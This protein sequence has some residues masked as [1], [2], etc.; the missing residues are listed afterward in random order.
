MTLSYGIAIARVWQE[1]ETV[2]ERYLRGDY[3]AVV[4]Q[5]ERFLDQYLGEAP[6]LEPPMRGTL[7]QAFIAA[8]RIDEALEQSER[9]LRRARE[10]GDPQLLG[11]ALLARA[12]ALA[13]SGAPDHAAPLLDELLAS[14]PLMRWFVWLAPL[15]LLLHELGR[16]D[17][18]IAACDAVPM[19]SRWRTAG[20]AAAGGDLRA[21]ADEYAAIGSRFVEAW[22]RLLAAEQGGAGADEQLARARTYFAELGAP[23]LL[24]RCELLLQDSA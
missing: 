20:I 10:I 3:V 6:Y 13:A 24:R 18:Y 11:G 2:L 12:S 14:T 23:A 9:S 8:G 15:P 16:G 21:A 4:P 1:G 17:D 22:A 19:Q 7:A 5:A